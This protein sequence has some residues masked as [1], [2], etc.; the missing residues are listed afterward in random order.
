MLTGP[1][2]ANIFAA[3]RGEKWMSAL[4][5]HVLVLNQ[6]YEPLS[7]CSVRRAVVMMYLGKAEMI[8]RFD[9]KV[10][11]SVYRSYPVPS[12]VRL[13]LYIHLPRKRVLLSRKNIVKRDNHRCQ[14]CGRTV[15]PMTVD[16]VIPKKLGGRDIWENLVCACLDC[17]NK[18]G[19]RTPDRA[20]MMLLHHPRRPDHLMYIQRFAGVNDSRWRRY[21]FLD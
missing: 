12:V 18:K 4:L 2:T 17:N 10:I 9:G 14:Y 3:W 6:N 1:G 8:E 20:R 5:G 7:V 13:G 21:L 15:A 11:R 16:H 19:D